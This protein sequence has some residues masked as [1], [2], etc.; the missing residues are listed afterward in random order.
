MGRERAVKGLSGPALVR[1]RADWKPNELGQRRVVRI[2]GLARLAGLRGLRE[3]APGDRPHLELARRLDRAQ[4]ETCLHLVAGRNLA[5]QE[6]DEGAERDAA[7]REPAELALHA[8]EVHVQLALAPVRLDVDDRHPVHRRARGPRDHEIGAIDPSEL[9]R[10]DVDPERS[11]RAAALV[12][13]ALLAVA[14]RLAALHPGPVER[15]ADPAEAGAEVLPAD[16]AAV[17]DPLVAAAVRRAPVG[18]DHAGPRRAEPARLERR[19]A[20]HVADPH[21]LADP[22]AGGAA[23]RAEQGHHEGERHGGKREGAAGPRPPA[24]SRLGSR[25]DLRTRLGD[26]L[27]E[28]GARVGNGQ[29]AEASLEQ[30]GGHEASLSS[31]VVRSFSRARAKRVRTVAAGTPSIAASS[32]ER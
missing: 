1:G 3:L 7:A 15:E 23:G 2:R 9:R 24:R 29:L 18:D 31:R 19:L 26:G 14:A 32:E 17:R 13:G 6:G 16:L 20:A 5:G 21:E 28:A 8:G 22:S 10:Q 27:G 12:A 11:E 25:G 30:V 4:V